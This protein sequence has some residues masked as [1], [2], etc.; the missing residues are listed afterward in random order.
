M[1]FNYLQYGIDHG[2]GLI[3]WAD[4][5]W[6]AMIGAQYAHYAP[7]VAAMLAFTVLHFGLTG[8]FLWRLAK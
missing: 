8:Y 7:L 2:K 5:P 6:S 3:T 4:M 1:P